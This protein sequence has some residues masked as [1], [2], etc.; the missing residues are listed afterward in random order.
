MAKLYIE[1][2]LGE[3]EKILM[4]SRQHWF[5]L[6][7]SI[8]LEVFAILVIF[9]ATIAG[10]FT[11]AASGQIYVFSIIGVGLVFLSVPIISMARDILIWSHRQY[12]I[13]NWRVIQVAG[14]FNKNVLDSSLDK[15][16]DVKMSQSMLGRSFGYGD[17]EIL[18]AS[19][20]GINL[21]RMIDEPVRFKTAMI[22][23]KEAAL[24]RIDAPATPG[25]DIPGLL[26]QLGDL[27]QKGI[28]T[29]EEFQEK[30]GLLLA[31]LK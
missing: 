31:K 16:N 29:E 6:A 8:T 23:A 26:A 19:E 28:L 27:H 12:I 13:T 30:K 17:I 5:V 3:N 1:N 25:S 2:M 15:I 24:H 14:I 21:F 11:V 18:T 7:R 22:N 9:I 10:A 4:S 20:E